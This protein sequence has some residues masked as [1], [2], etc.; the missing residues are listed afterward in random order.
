[1]KIKRKE[2][3]SFVKKISSVYG[4]SPLS[5]ENLLC[6]WKI[7]SVYEMSLSMKCPIYEMSYLWNVRLWNV[8]LWNVLCIKCPMYKTSYVWNVLS[9]KCPNAG[10]LLYPPYC[11]FSR[12]HLLHKTCWVDW[13]VR[14]TAYAVRAVPARNMKLL[15]RGGLSCPADRWSIS[16]L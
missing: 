13:T 3:I 9:M 2:K 7:F 5:M 4:K 14:R 15:E 12:L 16:S 11:D 8:F 10:F 1:M 6:L